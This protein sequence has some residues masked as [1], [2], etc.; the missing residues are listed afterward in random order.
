[1]SKTQ[2]AANVIR[3]Y[4]GNIFGNAS[5]SW[6]KLI[7]IF[8]CF[9]PHALK[10]VFRPVVY[11]TPVHISRDSSV[12][13]KGMHYLKHTNT[14]SAH[15]THWIHS[16]MQIIANRDTYFSC[17]PMS[18]KSNATKWNLNYPK[19]ISSDSREFLTL[20]YYRSH[21]GQPCLYISFIFF[22]NE[23]I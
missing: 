14:Q 11:A 3:K 2:S 4:C 12:K 5:H 23:T 6:H 8:D 1:M 21:L 22:S 20:Y 10:W 13:I 7:S 18:T 19:F 17:A 16:R 15:I 9:H